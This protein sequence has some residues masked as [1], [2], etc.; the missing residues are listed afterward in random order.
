M[1]GGI[2]ALIVFVVAPVIYLV[3]W[4]VSRER[5]RGRRD[6][7]RACG[8][9]NVEVSTFMGIETK[10]TGRAGPLGVRMDSYSRGK[11]DHGTRIVI[12]GL[13]HGSYALAIRG[14]G[15]TS[16]IEKAVGERE[17]EVGDD[18]FDRA[19]YLQGAPT[20]VRALFDVDTRR[21]MRQLLG[22]E[23]R[24]DRRGEV[25]ALSVRVSVSDDEL[26]VS[27]PD[28]LF[29]STSAWLPEVLPQLLDLGGRLRRPDDLAAKIAANTRV[30]PVPAVRLA[31]LQT[32][33]REFANHPATREALT[34]A[35]GDG[36]HGV[37]LHAALALGPDGRQ[38][39]ADIAGRDDAPDTIV[40]RAIEALG[41]DFG[42]ERAV[43]KLG[44]AIRDGRVAVARACIAII[45]GAGT[46]AGIEALA[47]LL[48][49]G[50]PDLGAA[51]AAALG[52]APNA[53]AEA[54]L[55][56]ALGSEAAEVRVAAAT[57][58]GRGCSPLAV[59]PLRN[60]VGRHPLDLE[61]RR[62]AR[63]A[64]AKIQERVTGASPGQ[65]SLAP[66]AAGQ[67]SL[68]EEDERGRVSLEPD[69]AK[70]PEAAARAR[71]AQV[72]QAAKNQV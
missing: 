39:L 70:E 18:A 6:A 53:A 9:T 52:A 50:P 67:V 30:E 16:A 2:G 48:R 34:P 41:A 36:D 33:A 56:E 10:L 26:R 8:L 55:I 68:A 17:L 32:L 24:V 7:A 64:I 61:L 46:P 40:A 29:T 13:R 57:A 27:I 45:G 44:P 20:L 51:A 38:V 71:R 4:G 69:A 21:L 14:E 72:E 25:K 5:S 63:E 31:N 65:L 1:D 60:V 11:S 66:D 37:R 47:G 58:L 19:A 22:G 23:I 35:L 62:A 59:V 43:E 3:V 28:R 54:A 15:V 12:D 42:P 49:A